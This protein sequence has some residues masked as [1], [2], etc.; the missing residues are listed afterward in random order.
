LLGIESD[1]SNRAAYRILGVFYRTGAGNAIQV[2]STDSVFSKE[3]AASWTGGSFSVSGNN[4]LV[5]VQGA[6]STTINWES[7]VTTLELE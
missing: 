6:A 1:N 3:T 2:S 4:V 7:I 5:E